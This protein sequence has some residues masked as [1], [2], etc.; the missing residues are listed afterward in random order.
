MSPEVVA[1]TVSL[2]G[3]YIALCI[4]AAAVK[5]GNLFRWEREGLGVWFIIFGIAAW[6]PR[7]NIIGFSLL[8]VFALGVVI[9]VVYTSVLGD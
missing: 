7:V 2:A 5:A 4:I 3:S 8:L 1:Y 6:I 9:H